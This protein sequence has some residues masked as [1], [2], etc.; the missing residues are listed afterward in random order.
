MIAQNFRCMVIIKSMRRI[1]LIDVGGDGKRITQTSK[2]IEKK[3]I[4][5]CCETN[6]EYMQSQIEI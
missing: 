3:P 2:Y 5:L 1:L 6:L 4:T